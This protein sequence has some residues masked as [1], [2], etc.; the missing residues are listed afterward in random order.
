MSGKNTYTGGT[1]IS[2][3]VLVLSNTLSNSSVTINQ[4]GALRTQNL[5]FLDEDSKN[6]QP[7]FVTLGLPH[8]DYALT[9][10]GSFEILKN[11]ILHGDYIGKEN[12]RL[13]LDVDAKLEVKGHVDM[14][15]GRFLLHSESIQIQQESFR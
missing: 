4:N 13:S 2:G 12:S 9:N 3:G 1:D 14:T 15:G 6:T 11:T 5:D 7:K 8:T 10:H